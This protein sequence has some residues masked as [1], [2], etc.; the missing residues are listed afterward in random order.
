MDW[1][2]CITQRIV[3]SVKKDKNLITST[4]EI[5][6]IKIESAGILPDI[7]YIAKISLLYDA[8]RLGFRVA[9]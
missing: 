1:R 4:R 5:A 2:E 9:R 7:Y 6:E 8:L 3:K